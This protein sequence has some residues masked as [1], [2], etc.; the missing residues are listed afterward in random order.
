MRFYTADLHLNS[1]NAIM[2][3]DRKFSDAKSMN[4]I[5]IK[6]INSRC[7]NTDTLVHVGDFAIVGRE[8]GKDTERVNPN[9]YIDRIKPNLILL[10]G[11]H[12]KS[13]RVKYHAYSI[14]TDIIDQDTEES[15]DPNSIDCMK[16]NM[17]RLRHNISVGHYPSYD[18]N[19]AGQFTK[20][21]IRICGH[22][23]KKW[24]FW[25]DQINDVLNINVGCDVWNYRPISEAEILNYIDQIESNMNHKWGVS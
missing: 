1:S 3:F 7:K 13:N 4:D 19:A 6:N 24:K 9:V 5:L 23:H 22:V 14:T 20:H 8:K 12:D 10:K 2:W 11:N 21:S 15:V 18:L 25:W 17:G 16:T